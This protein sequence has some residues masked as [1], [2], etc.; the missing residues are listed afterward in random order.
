MIERKQAELLTRYCGEVRKGDE[1]QIRASIEAMPLIKEIY[2]SVV[3]L[4]A[5]PRLAIEDEELQEI[6]Y[7]NA[8]VELLEYLSPIDKFISENVN[9]SFS[10]ISSTHVK[11]LISI[12]PEKLKVRSNALR[13][14]TEIFMRRDGEGSLRWTVT[15]YPTRALAQEANMS[16]IDYQEFVARALKLHLPDPVAAWQAQARSQEKIVALLSRVSELRVKDEDTDLLLRVDGRT[17]IN[18]E[19]KRNMPG[20]E[21]FTG[22]VEEATEGHITFTYPAVW[23]GYEVEGVR[24][25]FSRGSVIEARALKGEEFLRKMLEVDEGAR[26]LGEAAFGLNYDI[27]RHTKQI[28][29]DEKIGGTMHLALGASYPKTGGKNTSAIHWDMIKDMTKA[30]VYADGELVYENGRF[31]EEVL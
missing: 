26:R 24:L 18:D 15:L 28:L 16:I 9:V 22:P 30:R 2:K 29:F 27:K 8:P 11:P 6:F 20:G 17:W 5:Y 13:P 14:L 10:I 31:I 3:S 25:R 4:G 7:R 1:V 19:G 23:R 21:V 12:D